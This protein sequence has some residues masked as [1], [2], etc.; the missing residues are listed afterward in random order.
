MIIYIYIR[1]INLRYISKSNHNIRGLYSGIHNGLP[2]G[3]CEQFICEQLIFTPVWVK[4]LILPKKNPT[5][6]KSQVSIALVPTSCFLATGS[7][8]VHHV[9]PLARVYD[10]A[11]KK[12][13]DI[14]DRLQVSLG[15]YPTEKTAE[16]RLCERNGVGH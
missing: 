6:L 16:H 2:A 15:K 4:C 7:D 14:I 10:K 3:G 9:G 5:G 1:D 12:Q 13:I 8:R 11:A